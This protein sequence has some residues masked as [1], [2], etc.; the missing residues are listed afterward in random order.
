[1]AKICNVKSNAINALIEKGVMDKD[2][3]VLDAKFFLLNQQYT[4]VAKQK[5]GVTLEGMTFSTKSKDSPRLEKMPYYRTDGVVPGDVY[6]IPNDAFFEDLQVKHDIY[7]QNED[8]TEKQLFSLT[9]EVQP[10]DEVKMETLNKLNNFIAAAGANLDVAEITDTEGNPID[11]DAM[12]DFL[13]ATIKITD[14]IDKRPTAWNKLPEE[15]AHLWFRLLD[16]NSELKKELLDA[17][18]DHPT[19]KDVQES[20]YAKLYDTEFA[21]QEEAIGKVIADQI[22]QLEKDKLPEDSA[23]AKWWTNFINWVK[24]KLGVYQAPSEVSPVFSTAAARIL[25]SDVSDLMD[26]KEYAYLLK[27]YYEQYEAESIIGDIFDNEGNSIYID[28]TIENDSKEVQDLINKRYKL[29]SRFL[30]KTIDKLKTS[31]EESISQNTGGLPIA[32]MTDKMI[33][34]FF[35]VPITL[36]SKEG[37]F[38]KYSKIGISLN[39]DVKVDG[40]KKDELVLL[41]DIRNKI[42]EENP[43]LKTISTDEFVNEIDS[44]LA[45]VYSIRSEDGYVSQYNNY[46]LTNILKNEFQNNSSHNRTGYYVYDKY[47]TSG[48]TGINPFAW[49][50]VLTVNDDKDKTTARMLHEI[51]SDQVETLRK[52]IERKNSDSELKNKVKSLYLAAFIQMYGKDA[53]LK[54][55]SNEIAEY[56]TSMFDKSLDLTDDFDISSVLNMTSFYDRFKHKIEELRALEEQSIKNL[57]YAKQNLDNEYSKKAILDNLIY[58]GFKDD[59]LELYSM[60]YTME[61]GFNND[62]NVNDY[63]YEQLAS[64]FEKYTGYTID[65][66]NRFYSNY[67][68]TKFKGEDL[69]A[70]RSNELTTAIYKPTPTKIHL[71]NVVSVMSSIANDIMKTN[72]VRAKRKKSAEQFF[73]AKIAGLKKKMRKDFNLFLR[74]YI[75]NRNAYY[76]ANQRKAALNIFEKIKQDEFNDMMKNVAFNVGYLVEQSKIAYTLDQYIADGISKAGDI[77]KFSDVYLT[78]VLTDLIIKSKK[79]GVPLYFSG[80]KMTEL[81]QGNIRTAAIY[82]GPEEVVMDPI[83]KN[84]YYVELAKKVYDSNLLSRYLTDEGINSKNDITV[85]AVPIIKKAIAKYN[86]DNS[87]SSNI[88]DEILKLTGGKYLEVGIMYIGLSKIRGIDLKYESADFANNNTPTYRIDLTNF[89]L[90]QPV[91]YSLNQPK[92]DNKYDLGIKTDKNVLAED[93]KESVMKSIGAVKTPIIEQEFIQVANRLKNFNSQNDTSY[94]LVASEMENGKI[95]IDDLSQKTLSKNAP[96]EIVM[97]LINRMRKLFPEINFEFITPDQVAGIVDGQYAVNTNTVNAFSKD[98]TVYLVLGRFTPDMIVEEFLHPFVA[99]MSID[100]PELFDNLLNEIRTSFP[101]LVSK[102]EAQYTKERGFTQDD[103]N[104]EIATRGLQQG[105]TDR[106]QS[107]YEKEY[108][109]LKKVLN[110]ILDWIKSTIRKITG[111]DSLYVTDI[112][113]NSSISQIASLMDGSVSFKFLNVPTSTNFNLSEEEKGIINEILENATEEQKLVVKTLLDNNVIYN[114][115]EHSYTDMDTLE[116]YSSVT[117][118]IKGTIDDDGKFEFNRNV[119]TE[120]DFIMNSVALNRDWDFI[121]PQLV[122]INKDIARKF[123]DTFMNYMDAWRGTGTIVIPQLILADPASGTA[124]KMDMLLI[125]PKG[126]MD[127]ID[128]KTSLSLD[129]FTKKYDFPYE[130]DSEESVF[131]GGKLSTRQQHGIQQ[132]AYKRMIDIRSELSNFEVRSVKTMHFK[133][134]R[135]G[136]IITDFEFQGYVDHTLADYTEMVNKVIPTQPAE[137]SK[138][139][140]SL[141]QEQARPE[142]QQIIENIRTIIENMIDKFEKRRAY[143]EEINTTTRGK[144]VA[145]DEYLERLNNVITLMKEAMTSG[146]P[147]NAFYNL[148][149]YVNAEVKNHDQNIASQKGSTEAKLSYMLEAETDLLSYKDLLFNPENFLNN[150]TITKLAKEAM[151]S[152]DGTLKDIEVQIKDF[153]TD[154]VAERTNRDLTREELEKVIEE[155]EDISWDQFMFGDLAN[156]KDAILSNLDKAY[157]ALRQQIFDF[158]DGV[159]REITEAGNKV[160][161]LT[162][163]KLHMFDFMISTGDDGKITGYIIS[164]IGKQYYKLRRSIKDTLVDESG[165]TLKYRPVYNLT[166]VSKEDLDFNIKLQKAKQEQRKF[167]SPEEMDNNGNVVDGNYHKYSDEFKQ[168]RAKYQYIFKRLDEDGNVLFYEWRRRSGL[169]DKAYNQFLD[170]YFQPEVTYLGAVMEKGTFGSEFKGRVVE[171]SGRFAKSEYVEVREIAG[172]GTDM[173]DEKYVKLMTA[174]DPLGVAQREFYEKWTTLYDKLLKKLPASQAREMMN[175]LPVMRGSMLNTVKSK[176]EGHVKSFTKGMRDLNPFSIETYNETVMLDED[177]NII[178]SIPIF[179]TGDTKSEKRITNLENSIKEVYKDL[180]AKKITHDEFKVKRKKLQALIRMEKQKITKDE[181]STDMVK[182]IIDFAHMAEN[183]QVMSDFESSVKS[184]LRTMKTRK[185]TKRSEAGNVITSKV[186]SGLESGVNALFSADNALAVQRLEKWMDMVYYRTN[187]PFKSKW[188][189]ITRKLMRYMSLKGVGLNVFGQINNYVVGNINDATEAAG[190]VYFKKAA[191]IR[192]IKEYNSDFIL[193]SLVSKNTRKLKASRDS[194]SPFYEFNESDSKYEAL[195]KKYRMMRKLQSGELGADFAD[196]ILDSAYFLAESAE[197]NVQTKVGIAILMSRTFKN[198]VTNEEVSIYDA[199]SFDQKTGEL[200]LDSKFYEESDKDRYDT[201]N[202]VYEVNKSI[203]GNYSYE[204]RMVIQANL[205]GELAGQFHKWVYPFIR[206]QWGSEYYN[207]NLGQTEGRYRSFFRLLGYWRDMSSITEAWDTL[208]ENQKANHYKLLGQLAFF[209]GALGLK[210]LLSRLADDLDDDDDETKRLTNFFIYQFDR[211]QDEISAAINPPAAIQ[212]VKNPIALT[213]FISNAYEAL[214]ATF[215]FL[216]SP[217]TGEKIYITKGPNKGR[218][219]ISKE[220]GDILPI[221]DQYNRWRSFDTVKSFYVK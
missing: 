126:V 108:R 122:Y 90:Q 50:T 192:A 64:L 102:I 125:D 164:K 149:K 2:M 169:T 89:K 68:I 79:D 154:F 199:H 209:I 182:N 177:G 63:V 134:T 190:G 95:K 18:K 205:L 185:Y 198:K 150:P 113:S 151:I 181:I 46:R 214:G 12:V 116:Q 51:Q 8:D 136:D 193:N 132:H 37:I 152:I 22:K 171:R 141:S 163:D 145:S 9:S 11:A 72:T 45:N 49:G 28:S 215:N 52:S 146:S 58:R 166:A 186:N 178:K 207:E 135:D 148:I 189:S 167:N 81:T 69:S 26:A 15:A 32:S 10:I 219:K 101:D 140:R 38:K 5:Y 88:Y 104:L 120:F 14:N 201:T 21:L 43:E 103:I 31:F 200:I 210:I 159:A 54:Y 82:A 111:K 106:L 117:S 114:D 100:N 121:Q 6:A 98:G 112:P 16:D 99:A 97:D 107:G 71:S 86:K 41:N 153:V 93:T 180:A 91:L 61:E 142:N 62:E 179:Y 57:V 218:L 23:F 138:L 196:R 110:T 65:L 170:K 195:V 55:F 124:G 19:L 206:Q 173:R 157:K 40:V 92:S 7:H 4:N 17:I 144:T 147:A 139:I 67:K 105:L 70:D 35:P 33:K 29:K 130:I 123:Y 94:M 131:F 84:N 216:A 176:G 118:K 221:L 24:E 80:A 83:Q 184:I 30:N 119:G 66:G 168:A 128:L 20:D 47:F 197:Y 44:Y 53:Y 78:P 129:I 42:K 3:K 48:H 96:D 59:L 183:F 162:I 191:Y 25:A 60:A 213:T 143:F 1:M 156:S 188:G 36:F 174:T 175:R 155:A 75:V 158:V 208:T 220:W 217:V 76:A 27:Q 73:Y 115:E 212:F 77:I 194:N 56:F 85:D 137:K 34:D 187:N 161:A 74:S 109:G 13:N 127:I 133:S 211:I 204:D 165:N 160:A 39:S 202:Y 172:D 87:Y 203:H